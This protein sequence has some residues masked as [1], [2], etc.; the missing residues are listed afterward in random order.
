MAEGPGADVDAGKK[1][2]PTI[3]EPTGAMFMLRCAELNLS[4][5]ALSNMTIGMVY[6]MLIEK[7]NDREEY[8]YRA[9]QADI[10]AFFGKG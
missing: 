1:I 9:T 6:D 4:D 8:P 7:A 10:E 3:R 2:R 5:E